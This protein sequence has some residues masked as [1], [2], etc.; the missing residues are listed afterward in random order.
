M[1]DILEES[2]SPEWSQAVREEVQ[3]HTDNIQIYRAS[4]KEQNNKISHH[5]VVAAIMLYTLQ[6]KVQTNIHPVLLS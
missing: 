6:I 3:R 1:T 4:A 2:N 5:A